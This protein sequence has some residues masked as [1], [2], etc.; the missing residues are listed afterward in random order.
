MVLGAVHGIPQ[1]VHVDLGL[2]EHLVKSPS[3]YLEVLVLSEEIDQLLLGCDLASI[4]FAQLLDEVPHRLD[5]LL[6][7]VLVI[8]PIEHQEDIQSRLTVGRCVQH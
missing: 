2:V 7:Q 8:L 4:R 6:L 5:L 1:F 3:I